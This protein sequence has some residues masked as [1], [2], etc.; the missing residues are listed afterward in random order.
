MPIVKKHLTFLAVLFAP[1]FLAA[2]AS[3]HAT[4][5]AATFD[6]L[7]AAAVGIDAYRASVEQ[8]RTAGTV[9]ETQWA[10]FAK[11]YNRAND[12]IIMAAKLLRDVGGMNADTP[13][14][15]D[16]AVATL[17]EFVITILPPKTKATP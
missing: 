16:A 3:Y 2:C 10:D 9:T 12:S 11:N 1:L 17:V 4:P 14:E 15:V 13:A 5:Q 8:A 6:T 7:K